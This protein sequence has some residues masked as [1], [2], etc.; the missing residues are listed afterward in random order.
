MSLGVTEKEAGENANGEK[1][2]G[3]T[4][5]NYVVCGEKTSRKSYADSPNLKSSVCKLDEW[6][7]FFSL[8]GSINDKDRVATMLFQGGMPI[9]KLSVL[10]GHS[11]VTMTWHFIRQQTPDDADI[12]LMEA[13]LN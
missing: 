10:L 3:H 12:E 8:S 1:Y 5:L 13:V 4:C 9:N 11:T 2:N 6:G 7:K